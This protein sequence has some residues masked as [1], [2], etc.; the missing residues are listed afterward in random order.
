MVGEFQD[1]CVTDDLCLNPRVT[2]LGSRWI[3]HSRP[4]TGARAFSRILEKLEI[5]SRLRDRLLSS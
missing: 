2:I 4:A 3:A 5:N 1:L